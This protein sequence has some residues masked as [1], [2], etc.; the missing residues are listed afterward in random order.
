MQTLS[1]PQAG[2]YVLAIEVQM[3][4]QEPLRGARWVFFSP[5][6]QFLYP[7]STSDWQDDEAWQ[8]MAHG[9]SKETRTSGC[10]CVDRGLT[11]PPGPAGRDRDFGIVAITTAGLPPGPYN[12]TVTSDD[13]FKLA[14][15]G[16]PVL[17]DWRPH[18]PLRYVTAVE[19]GAARQTVRVDYF[20][21]EAGFTLWLRA[22]PFTGPGA[23]FAA[24]LSG[25][26]PEALRRRV[27]QTAERFE[28]DKGFAG[29]VSH[30]R[31]AGEIDDVLANRQ[32]DERTQNRRREAQA[33]TR[34]GKHA[35]AAAVYKQLIPTSRD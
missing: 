31:L 10:L 33:L 20:Q 12:F 9:P 26:T 2:L 8:A 17:S 5:W 18:G 4:R 32:P 24:R 21:V 19:L 14:V 34:D 15:D 30:Y 29:A 13:G 28:Q 22:E 7:V 6:K 16:K 23:V 11:T 35:E 3:D 1:Q 25:E 27:A